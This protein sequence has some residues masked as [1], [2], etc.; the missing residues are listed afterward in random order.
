[1]DKLTVD[2]LSKKGGLR[3]KRVLVR[4]DF[5]VPMSKDIEGKIADDKRIVESLP[6]IK[7][8]VA[9]GGIVILMSHM[10]RPK[11]EKNLKYSLRPV[12]MHLTSLLGE[13][14]FF[15][16][17][18]IGEDTEKIVNDLNNGSILLLENLRFYKEEEDNDENFAKKLASYGDI[19]INDAFGTA[20]RAHASTVGVTKFIDKSAAG[21]LMQKEI[22]AAPVC[23]NSGRKQDIRKD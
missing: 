1:L 21:Y 13:S 6:T 23:C 5:N 4:V 22:A 8:I 14:V 16:D 10:G 18:C 9:D 2:D 11:G 3:G 7:K 19:Y 15:S 12:A 20:H 17:D